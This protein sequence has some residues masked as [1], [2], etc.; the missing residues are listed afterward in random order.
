MRKFPTSSPNVLT[1]IDSQ[2]DN[3]TTFNIQFS[4]KN[5]SHTGNPF[6]DSGRLKSWSDLKA[7]HDLID[8][9]E[10]F[11]WVQIIH[12]I[13]RSWKE[14]F[15]TCTDNIS[16]L[17]SLY[18]SIQCF[19]KR[20][21]PTA[22]KYFEEHF[23]NFDLLWKN[24]YILSHQVTSD[25]KLCIYQYKL[26]PNILYLISSTKLEYLKHNLTF[27]AYLKQKLTFIFSV[28]KN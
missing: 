1:M 27:S 19:L 12:V 9:Q 28:K 20:E 17:I 24:K 15:L 25:T 3:S 10:H 14:S 7:K 13:L 22:E 16:P 21:Q 4:Q 8:K 2:I 5:I 26:L 18:R 11:C 23:K 6:D